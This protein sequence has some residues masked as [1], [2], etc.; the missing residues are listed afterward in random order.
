MASMKAGES[1]M[2]P[3]VALAAHVC[4][5]GPAQGFALDGEYAAGLA[6]VD[7]LGLALRETCRTSKSLKTPFEGFLWVLFFF[8]PGALGPP[9]GDECAYLQMWGFETHPHNFPRSHRP[10]SSCS[11]VE[12]QLKAR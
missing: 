5:S 12:G 11:P 3:S 9:L 4:P 6:V 1:S 2:H 7:K 8:V 10:S